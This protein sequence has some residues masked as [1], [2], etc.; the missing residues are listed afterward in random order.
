MLYEKKKTALPNEMEFNFDPR[1][2]M[3]KFSEDQLKGLRDAFDR[4]DEKNTGVC[5]PLELKS[6]FK[7]SGCDKSNPPLYSMICWI[8]DANNFSGT[9]TMTFDEFV[10]YSTYFFSQKQEIEGLKYIF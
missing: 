9:E 6:E 1:G 3:I 8:A 7:K 4:F 10:E 5:D 2:S